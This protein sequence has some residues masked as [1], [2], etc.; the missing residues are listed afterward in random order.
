MKFVKSVDQFNNAIT[1]DN[2]VFWNCAYLPYQLDCYFCRVLCEKTGFDIVGEHVSVI[3]D[4]IYFD[5]APLYNR[6]DDYLY[7][8][9]DIGNKQPCID[10]NIESC[11]KYINDYLL[12]RYSYN[13]MKLEDLDCCDQMY[14]CNGEVLLCWNENPSNLNNKDKYS[15]I[16]VEKKGNTYYCYYN[17]TCKLL[18]KHVAKMPRRY[19]LIELCTTMNMHFGLNSKLFEHSNG[20]I[21]YKDHPIYIEKTDTFCF[22]NGKLADCYICEEVPATE[23]SLKKI[24]ELVQFDL[25]N[26]EMMTYS[27]LAE[28]IVKGNGLV[29]DKNDRVDTGIY[30]KLANENKP[31]DDLMIKKFGTDSWTKP[32][33][34]LYVGK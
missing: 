7:F 13:G 22:N 12:E 1:V 8:H 9:G 11:I 27:E 17:T 28:W 18:F 19:W 2:D 4:I 26:E 21:Y 3:N 5:N 29:K 10:K 25:D 33:K 30:Y 34:R 16:A 31:V 23:S 20:I 32:Y 6:H 15:P 24:Y 14:Y